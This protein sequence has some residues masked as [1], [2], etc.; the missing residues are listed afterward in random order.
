MITDMTRGGGQMYRQ[1]RPSNAW[2]QRPATARARTPDPART[3]GPNKYYKTTND[4]NELLAN[5]KNRLHNVTIGAITR[6]L[7][8]LR[9][10]HSMNATRTGP[11][12]G[13]FPRE[14]TAT[15]VIDH[16]FAIRNGK[17]VPLGVMRKRP[18]AVSDKNNEVNELAY[19]T[20]GTVRVVG[21]TTAKKFKHARL[22]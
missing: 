11:N 1:P 7:R 16:K 17:W 2:S 15:S 10:P 13:W 22:Y 9:I 18:I 4:V 14:R 6:S 21:P 19:Y 3:P 20:D 5:V 8:H 12:T